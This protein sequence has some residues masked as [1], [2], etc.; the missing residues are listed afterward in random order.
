MFTKKNKPVHVGIAGAGSGPGELNPTSP[1]WIFI[2]KWAKDQLAEAR[3]RNDNMNLSELNTAI[4]RG[5]IDALKDLINLPDPGKDMPE[6]PEYTL[7]ND[8]FAGY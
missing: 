5:R 7:D 3:L 6:L 1:T 8:R 2:H 4:L